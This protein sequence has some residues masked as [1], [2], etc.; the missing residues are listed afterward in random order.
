M[1][2]LSNKKFLKIVSRSLSAINKFFLDCL[3]PISCLNCHTFN[4]W[5]CP[6]CLS[7]I[8][9]TTEDFCPACE[10]VP[11]PDGKTCFACKNKNS[12]DGLLVCCSY[13]ENVVSKAIHSLKYKFIS[14]LRQPLGK[15]MIRKILSSSLPLPDCLIPVPLYSKRLRWRGFNQ[16][17]L[18]AKYVGKNLTPGLK[19]PTWSNILFRN[20]N[21]RAQMSIRN[22]QQ[23][24]ENII[25]AFSI[26][27]SKK[28]QGKTI[29]LIDDVA[30]TGA[31]IFECAKTL[32]NN[33]A[34]KVFALV[35]ARQEIKMK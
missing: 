19:I 27:N 21:T 7:K 33:G 34:K 32:K 18:L 12:L 15:I 28:I 14:D 30:T 8:K 16:S 20:K 13:K 24:K 2:Y 3:L 26:S 35:I 17:L 4:Q 22:Y 1:I 29:L 23:R 5:I 31:T 25:N 11:T 9:I 10:K 6:N